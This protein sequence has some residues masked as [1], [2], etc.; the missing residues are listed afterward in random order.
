MQIVFEK[1]NFNPIFGCKFLETNIFSFCIYHLYKV[2]NHTSIY[3]Y[4]TNNMLYIQYWI[5]GVNQQGIPLGI[6]QQFS[7]HLNFKCLF[8]TTM[9]YALILNFTICN[10]L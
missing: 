3:V 4:N 9:H 1:I 8:G 7:V 2:Q 10:S 5:I 6:V